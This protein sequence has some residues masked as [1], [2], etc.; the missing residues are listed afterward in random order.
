MR[1]KVSIPRGHQMGRR[2][3]LVAIRV[4]ARQRTQARTMIY[5]SSIEMVQGCEISPTT[6]LMIFTPR[7]HRMG[8]TL[9]LCLSAMGGPH[10]QV[11]H[12]WDM[13]P[14]ALEIA[15]SILWRRMVPTPSI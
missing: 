13:R 7:G 12:P 15:R 6:L 11:I 2:S 14:H 10:S 1:A 8:C 4:G 3:L 5:A 9:L